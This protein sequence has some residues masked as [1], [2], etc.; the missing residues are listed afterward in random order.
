MRL[1]AIF[2]VLRKMVEKD[3]ATPDDRMY[4]EWS[5]GYRDKAMGIAIRRALRKMGVTEEELAPIVSRNSRLEA[6]FMN[7]PRPSRP[8]A[9]EV[10]CYMYT[11][12]N[13]AER[14]D[15]WVYRRDWG[16]RV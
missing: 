3:W 12:L 6:T 10:Y 1:A 16:I 5:A 7:L 8:P 15:H 14:R 11:C 4:P 9:D 2:R 13:F